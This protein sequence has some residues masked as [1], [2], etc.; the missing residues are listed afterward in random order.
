MKLEP[1][2]PERCVERPCLAMKRQE[3]SAKK[4]ETNSNFSLISQQTTI[5]RNA[6]VI[7]EPRAVHMT[8]L[9]SETNANILIEFF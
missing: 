7:F 8:P 3:R 6:L 4:L 9:L 2:S 1:Q 5:E